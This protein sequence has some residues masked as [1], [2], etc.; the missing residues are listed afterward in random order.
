[1]PISCH[2]QDCKIAA[3]HESSHVSSAI[4]S[5]QTF[6]HLENYGITWVGIPE[7]LFLWIRHL[8][9]ADWRQKLSE[10]ASECSCYAVVVS[11]DI[12]P[13]E[14]DAEHDD[15]DFEF[16]T[17]A[18]I[19]DC[20]NGWHGNASACTVLRHWTA[21][22]WI[23][24]RHFVYTLVTLAILTSDCLWAMIYCTPSVQPEI[25]IYE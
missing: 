18:D 12:Q 21:S 2:F 13:N 9:D 1:M 24:T 20:G 6:Y 4:A 3:V 5:T 7:S 8:S 16:V 14:L 19:T 10:C 11:E 22:V 25:I 17:A 15:I 23:T